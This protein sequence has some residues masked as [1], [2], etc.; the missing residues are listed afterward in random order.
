MTRFSN[1]TVLISGGAGGQGVSHL[2]AYLRE[3]AN[4]VIGDIDDSRGRAI[5]AEAGDRALY[6]HL[7]VTDEDDWSK[8]VA[9]TEERFGPISVLV[10]NAGIGSPPV[11]IEDGTL[12]DWQR[13]IA[14]NITGQYLGIRATTPSLRR[15]GGGSIVNIASM[16]ADTGI[17]YL[18]PYVVSKWGVRGLTRT[19]ALELARD[20]IRV[21]SVHPGVV[22]T[23]FITEPL[24]PGLAPVSNYYSAEP[25]AI[26]RLA[27]PQE[28]TNVVLFLSSD[29]AA[30]VT[31]SDFV[32]DGGMLL[33][34][35]VPAAA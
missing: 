35:A 28:I 10:N 4:V 33:G 21:N 6:L 31:G 18:A 9:A 8:A 13:V 12:D 23:P 30:Y 19:A 2:K 15:A 16:A 1:K 34:P 11:L 7:D 32:V 5:A 29:E 26:K 25:Y 3:G 14:V 24:R 22:D 27:E 17:A 20:G